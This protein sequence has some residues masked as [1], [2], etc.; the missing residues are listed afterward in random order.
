MHIAKVTDLFHA[1]YVR[2]KVRWQKS[3]D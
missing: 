2:C 3:R 1:T